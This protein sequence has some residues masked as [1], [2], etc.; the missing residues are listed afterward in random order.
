MKKS[1]LSVGLLL[2]FFLLG[3]NPQSDQPYS[4]LIRNGRVLGRLT[5]EEG[6]LTLMEALRKMTIMPAEQLERAS[7][8]MRCR[9][10]LTPGR[11]ADITIFDPDS[12]IDRAT[13]LESAQ[14]SK[15]VHYVL[16]NGTVVLDR[17]EFV[18][19][20]TPGRPI[21]HQED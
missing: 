4:I 3:T 9:G 2:V 1:T 17:G 7:P 13:Y 12:I 14:Y 5:R 16:V 20:V 8:S 11:Y 18:D 6:H 10:R 21:H 15:G 19:G